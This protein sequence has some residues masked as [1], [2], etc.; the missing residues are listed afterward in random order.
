[1]VKKGEG[2][3]RRREKKA[4]GSARISSWNCLIS[5]YS[6]LIKEWANPGWM[7]RKRAARVDEW[8][9]EQYIS[10]KSAGIGSEHKLFYYFYL[11]TKLNIRYFF[12]VNWRR[13]QSSFDSNAT[14]CIV[15]VLE[16][17]CGWDVRKH[18]RNPSWSWWERKRRW[19]RSQDPSQARN[20]T[21][22][23][24]FWNTA[25]WSH[26]RGHQP[27]SGSAE[28]SVIDDDFGRELCH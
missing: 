20:E 7:S 1:M 10:I 19:N 13:M 24:E 9:E 16:L 5:F 23:N 26:R 11:T 8:V 21:N 4:T 22:P 25:F 3:R 28:I 6:R 17:L 2:R 14:L 15:S 12:G 18:L 27:A